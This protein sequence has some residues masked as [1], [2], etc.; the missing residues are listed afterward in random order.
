M[1]GISAKLVARHRSRFFCF[2]FLVNR[3]RIRGNLNSPFDLLL[4]T[5]AVGNNSVSRNIKHLQL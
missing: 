1:T 5:F 4:L 3:F 2:R